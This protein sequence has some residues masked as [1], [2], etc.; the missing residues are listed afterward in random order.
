MVAY[1]T[2]ALFLLV[3][4]HCGSGG[5]TEPLYDATM[6]KKP[7]GS[8]YDWLTSAGRLMDKPWPLCDPRVTFDG[9]DLP[10]ADLDA[11]AE[12]MLGGLRKSLA[13]PETKVRPP[14]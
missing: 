9:R 8:R 14:A 12:A 1:R 4:N 7:D 2:N 3:L 13:E 6:G 10:D 5:E 11:L